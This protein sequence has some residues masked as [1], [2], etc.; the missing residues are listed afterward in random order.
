ME[1]RIPRFTLDGVR[2]AE[3]SIH[4]FAT[5]DE[6]GLTLTR[7]RRAGGPT[8]EGTPDDVVLLIHGLTSS[9]DM[10]IMPEH[11]NLVG[12]LH[13]NGFGDVWALDFR[14]SNRFPYNVETRRHTLDDIAHFDYPAALRE[15]RRHVGARRIHVI[16]HCL[17][18]LSFSMSLFAGAVDGIASLVANSVALTPRVHRWS[19][20][21]LSL[22]PVLMEYGTGLSYLDPRF[23]DAP[24]LTRRWLLARAVSLL[25]PE[26]REPACHMQSFMWGSGK[27]AM[28]RHG[29]LRPE[30]HL[31][32]R[33]ADLNGACD[34][35]YYRHVHKMVAAGQ[36]VRFDPGDRRHDDLGDDYLAA[37]ADV[38][39]PILLMT[40][41]H[42]DVF[43]DSNIVCHERLS[44]AAPG[45]HELRVL[46]GYGHIDTLIG[47]DAHLDVFP[48]ILDFIKRH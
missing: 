8:A 22:G 43:T 41:D 35:H 47:K 46:P 44:E 11:T 40:G 23:K 5:E 6:L 18:S 19:R 12:F 39:T 2:E 29:N 34:M 13:E 16:A 48:H 30:T 14:M 28:Y 31:H 38:T 45:R 27:P 42:N 7:F 24:P 26:C 25:H 17:G 4:P 9:S 10:F 20:V 1:H 21:K 37:A 32:E 3:V 33:L 36:A 15:L